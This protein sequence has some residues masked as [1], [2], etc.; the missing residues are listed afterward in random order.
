MLARCRLG[1]YNGDFAAE[2]LVVHV[3]YLL[4]AASLPV[5]NANMGELFI[6]VSNRVL[7]NA[8]AFSLGV[9]DL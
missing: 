7:A 8:S 1:P 3:L 4:P 9:G 6:I 5:N 2:S